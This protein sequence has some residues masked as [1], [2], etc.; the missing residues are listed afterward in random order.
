MFREQAQARLDKKI[1]YFVIDMQHLIFV[2]SKGLESLIW[3]QETC[4]EH[5]GQIRL[6]KPDDTCMK[7]LHVTR[8][9]NRFDIFS[10]VTEAV[11]T[12]R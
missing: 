5:L 9:D 12:M 10:D 8:L 3:L 4:D 6:C 7:I 2:D 1:N 11:K